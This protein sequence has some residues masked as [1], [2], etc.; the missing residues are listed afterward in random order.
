MRIP[1]CLGAPSKRVVVEYEGMTFYLHAYIHTYTDISIHAVLL[2]ILLQHNQPATTPVVHTDVYRCTPT[3]VSFIGMLIR[4]CHVRTY[5]T[6][7][8]GREMI[9]T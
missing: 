6:L 5:V 2:L 8:R 7:D 9:H 1:A 3:S 4:I